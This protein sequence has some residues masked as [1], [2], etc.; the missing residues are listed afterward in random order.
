MDTM[1]KRSQSLTTLL[2]NLDRQVIRPGGLVYTVSTCANVKAE[3]DSTICELGD[4]L[5]LDECS[6]QILG[7]ALFKEIG[8]EK[9]LGV[10][11]L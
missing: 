9:H 8:V 1:T 10:M 4:R 5:H 7:F 11:F 6:T 2:D 3:A